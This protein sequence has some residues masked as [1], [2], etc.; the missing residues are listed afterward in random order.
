MAGAP[1][2]ATAAAVDGVYTAATSKGHKLT[3]IIMETFGGFS[4][5][6][7]AL[8]AR[9]G[10]LHGQKLGL[11]EE[12][13]PWCARSFRS[14]HTMR[15]SVALH[16]AAADEILQLAQQDAAAATRDGEGA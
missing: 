10:R 3:L 14:L 11:D 2:T 1:A 8:M 7:V 13:A 6:A 12:A 15:I 5:E 9:L 16:C 4:P